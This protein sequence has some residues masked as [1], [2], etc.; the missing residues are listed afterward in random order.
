MPSG[1]RSGPFA[2]THARSG[3]RGSSRRSCSPCG[4]AARVKS[5][6]GRGED[7]RRAL[8]RQV[9]NVR[10]RQ[11]LPQHLAAPGHVEMERAPSPTRSESVPSGRRKA[12]SSC[13]EIVQLGLMLVPMDDK[14]VDAVAQR[15]VHLCFHG[16]RILMPVLP[17]R[18]SKRLRADHGSVRMPHGHRLD[19][20]VTPSDLPSPW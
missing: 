17:R 11:A 10:D 3:F 2:P 8:R 9:Q 20:A 4:R 12:P 19:A 5:R 6:S 13:R 18:R 7:L 15:P 1:R 16:A 14:L